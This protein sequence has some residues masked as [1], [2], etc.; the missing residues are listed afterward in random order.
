MGTVDN[1]FIIHS[2]ITHC[3]NENKKLFAAFIDFKK[4]F[5]YVVKRCTMVQINSVWL[6]M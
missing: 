3:T 4:A 6:A 1:V 2:L 5:D